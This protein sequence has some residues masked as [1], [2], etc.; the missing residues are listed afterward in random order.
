MNK[1]PLLLGIRVTSM[2]LEQHF[3]SRLIEEHYFTAVVVS[4]KLKQMYFSTAYIILVI[5]TKMIVL[6]SHLKLYCKPN[7]EITKKMVN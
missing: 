6:V 3:E 1:V 4:I 5:T 7:I 2:R